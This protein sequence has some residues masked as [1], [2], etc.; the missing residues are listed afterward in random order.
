[1][2][3]RLNRSFWPQGAW[4]CKYAGVLYHTVGKRKEKAIRMI[5]DINVLVK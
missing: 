1:M 2:I 3:K 5:S 4:K